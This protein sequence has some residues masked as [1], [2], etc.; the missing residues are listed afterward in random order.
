M[1]AADL[2]D[3]FVDA[4][5]L[6][7]AF[8]LDDGD[9]DAVNQK[10]NIRPVRFLIPTIKPV[11]KLPL[12]RYVEDVVGRMLKIDKGDVPVALLAFDVNR[13]LPAQPR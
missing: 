8:C 3:T 13:A 10:D 12:I 4:F 11:C 7:G 6:C 9:G 2:S 1:I 5:G